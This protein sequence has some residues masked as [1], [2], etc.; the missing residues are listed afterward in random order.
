MKADEI[1]TSKGNRTLRIVPERGPE[2][3]LRILREIA[4]HFSPEAFADSYTWNRKHFPAAL[5]VPSHFRD[6][7]CAIAVGLNL[8][9]FLKAAQWVLDFRSLESVI[10]ERDWYRLEI[11][12]KKMRDGISHEMEIEN[13][14]RQKRA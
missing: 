4:G 14:A 7:I 12:L 5:A 13:E 3:Q 11:G 9:Q 8:D 2:E 10:L 1:R 6:E